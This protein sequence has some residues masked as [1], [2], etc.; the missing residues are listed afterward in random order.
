MPIEMADGSELPLSEVLDRVARKVPLPER[1]A[2]APQAPAVT[3]AP[4]VNPPLRYRTEWSQ[5]TDEQRQAARAAFR[6]SMTRIMTDNYGPT[7]GLAYQHEHDGH[8][9]Q[10][11]ALY[12]S[13][14]QGEPGYAYSR[15]RVGWHIL[16]RNGQ[17][18][19]GLRYVQE[20]LH[21]DPL[22]GN[23]WQDMGR[24]YA[25]ILGVPGIR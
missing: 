2:A 25:K 7:F 1:P 11:I 5:L 6:A 4:T 20:A 13:I 3:E 17:P 16:A 15:R 21:A 9:D 12:L 23:S 18:A 14:K 8:D 19:R 22:N 24:V 10:A